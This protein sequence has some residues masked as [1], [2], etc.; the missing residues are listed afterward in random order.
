[1]E[2][3]ARGIKT[4][5][6]GLPK[7]EHWKTLGEPN[8]TGDCKGNGS[9]WLLGKIIEIG[10]HRIAVGATELMK[11][12]RVGGTSRAA[13][14]SKKRGERTTLIISSRK[15]GVVARWLNIVTVSHKGRKGSSTKER[16]W[17]REQQGGEGRLRSSNI[18]P[19]KRKPDEHGPA[20]GPK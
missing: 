8:F 17:P 14:Q 9:D 20:A 19:E 18:G 1:V 16:N 10:V 13:R 5:G 11:D 2:R 15:K 3:D 7:K 6:P 12:H 4:A